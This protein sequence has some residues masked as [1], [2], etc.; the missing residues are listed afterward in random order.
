MSLSVASK[1]ATL[2]AALWPAGERR[3]TGALRALALA[4]VGSLLLTISAKVQVPFWPVPMTMQTFAVVV[5]GMAYGWRLAGAAVL[6]YLVEGAAGLPVFAGTPERGIGLVYMAGPTG[7]YLAGFFLAAVLCGWLAERGWDRRLV[8]ALAAM[9]LGHAVIFV[10]GL[11]WLGQAIGVQKAIAV[12]FTPFLLGTVVKT[13]LAAA[14][15][16]ASW[17]GI[18]RRRSV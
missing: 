6:L 13:A 11:G 15:L 10:F 2:M 18:E 17:L 5:I 8:P 14:V 1:P 12:G 16:W 4:V 7:G 9:L 3:E